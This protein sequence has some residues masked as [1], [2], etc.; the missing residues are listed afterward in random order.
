MEVTGVVIHTDLQKGVSK[1]GREWQKKN[2]V[3]EII[4][5]VTVKRLAFEIFGDERI[6]A[7][8]F[9]EGQNVTV[10]FDIESTEWNGRW[11]T[12]LKAWRVSK[13][14]TTTTSPSISAAKTAMKNSAASTF[15]TM[16]PSSK[17]DELPF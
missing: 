17:A 3:L 2:F 1:A 14:D 4:E 7:N 8:P 13:F 5:G 9:S 10:Q 6:E 16:L 12:T 11:F 15:P